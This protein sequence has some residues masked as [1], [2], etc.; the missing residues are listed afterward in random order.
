[1]WHIMCKVGENV[2]STLSKNE[3][4]R[5]KLKSIV[6]SSY[7]EPADFESKWKLLMKEFDL[8][9]NNRFVQMLELRR[10]WISSYF[11]N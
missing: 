10:F 1:M 3:V 9:N 7:L 11:R 4:F 5:N 2:G 6:L 8:V